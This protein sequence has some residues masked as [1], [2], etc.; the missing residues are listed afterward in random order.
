VTSTA[1]E[2]GAAVGAWNSLVRRARIGSKYK[3]AAL[4]VSSYADPDGTGIHC[5]IA[6]LATD[7]D[8]SYS[9]AR[10]YLAWL[11][12]VGLIELVREGNHR[13]KRSDEY[14]L[15]LG[16]N[17]MEHVEV[18][19]PTRYKELS[20]GLREANRD[21]S[22]RRTQATDLRS[23]RVSADKADIEGGNRGHLRSS[24]VSADNAICA[25]NEADLRSSLCERPPPLI[26]SPKRSTSPTTDEKDLRTDLALVEP[27]EPE[28]EP[29]EPSVVVEIRPGASLEPPYAAPP[30]KLSR[31]QQAVAEA[32]ARRAAAFAAHRAHKEA[33]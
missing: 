4:I 26:T 20:D 5:G 15:I 6:R 28:P 9:T 21:G 1:H 22:R 8:A 29:E 10:R 18:L 23:S 30:K 24:K 3:L 2:L 19:D 33:N 32:T 25:Q 7:L 13:R 17:V 16:P 11:R 27:P 31:G 14:R 12:Q